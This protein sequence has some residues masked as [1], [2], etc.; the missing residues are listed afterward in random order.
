VYFKQNMPVEAFLLKKLA[1]NRLPKT[2]TKLPVI[3]RGK[4]LI[5]YFVGN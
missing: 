4:A 5:R 3:S 1:F 2:F